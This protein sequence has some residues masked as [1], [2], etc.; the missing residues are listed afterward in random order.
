MGCFLDCYGSSTGKDAKTMGVLLKAVR[1]VLVE[2]IERIDS[3]Q[4]ATTEEQE[5]MFLNL[6]TMI[7]D[8]D[9]RVSKYDACR[10]LGVSR[11]KF[12]RMIKDGKLPPGKKT[13]GWKELSWSLKE[14]D[15]KARDMRS[16]TLK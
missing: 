15:D 3:G 1:K 11:A 2:L 13:T 12:D 10:H 9:R 6:C 7:A 8:K 16:K 4:C 14:L 5:M